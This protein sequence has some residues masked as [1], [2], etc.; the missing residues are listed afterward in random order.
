MN[1]KFATDV[2][3]N[4]YNFIDQLLNTPNLIKNRFKQLT[5]DFGS[6]SVRTIDAD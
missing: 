6:H 2:E 4:F 1:C 5:L 3:I